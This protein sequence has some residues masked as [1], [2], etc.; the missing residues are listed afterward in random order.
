[1]KFEDYGAKSKV[2]E[3][4]KNRVGNILAD[5]K[6]SALFG[7]FLESAPDELGEAPGAGKERRERLFKD[8]STP[9]DKERLIEQKKQFLERQKE[10][11]RVSKAFT[12]KFID[13]LASYSPQLETLV[14]FGGAEAV[15]SALTSKLEMFAMMQPEHFGEIVQAYDEVIKNAE[16]ANQ[17]IEEICQKYNITSKEY[18]DVMGTTP[19]E[20]ERQKKLGDLIKGKMGDVKKFWKKTR[21][22]IQ[23]KRDEKAGLQAKEMDFK[24]EIDKLRVEYDK[25]LEKVGDVLAVSIEQDKSIHKAFMSA[26]RGEKAPKEEQSG[27]FKEMQGLMQGEEVLDKESKEQWDAFVKDNP[28][29]DT[30]DEKDKFKASY[31]GKKLRGKTGTWSD[32]VKSFMMEAIKK[33]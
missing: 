28:T 22:K 19:D 14:E 30:A 7:Q 10:V 16:A 2:E 31:V 32:H 27:G 29:K 3:K 23:A 18:L 12:P 24:E 33:W 15:H 26:M 8:E 11:E 5:K 1:M 25:E 21:E 4:T 13:Q 6:Q 20:T 17:R 9:E